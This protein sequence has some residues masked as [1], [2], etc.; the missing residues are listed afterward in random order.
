MLKVKKYQYW[1]VKLPR[2]NYFTGYI[3]Q[4]FSNIIRIIVNMINQWSIYFQ[5][6]HLIVMKY[7]MNDKQD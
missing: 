3:T 4:H 6:D 5:C 1:F 7:E 2:R